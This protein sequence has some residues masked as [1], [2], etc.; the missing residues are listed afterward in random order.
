MSGC[1]ASITAAGPHDP[2]LAD[3]TNDRLVGPVRFIGLRTYDDDD[4]ASLVGEDQWIKTIAMLD[5]GLRVTLQV[6]PGQRDWM[7]VDYGGSG[8]RAVTLRA[9][10]RQSTAYAGGFTIDYARAPRQG[11][12]AELIV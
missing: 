12:C 4:W 8:G 6:P 5:A 3:D 7:R 10:R 1:R 2:I 9:C 11:R